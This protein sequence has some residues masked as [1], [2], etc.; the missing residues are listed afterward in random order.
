MSDMVTHV[1][2]KV[3]FRERRRC[4]KETDWEEN[5]GCW[6]W[7]M[8]TSKGISVGIFYETQLATA[9]YLIM[10]NV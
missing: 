8:N 5:L 9:L 10:K 7:D 2:K 4:V 6:W 3:T 1:L